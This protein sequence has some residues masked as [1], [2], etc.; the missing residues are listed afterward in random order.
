MDRLTDLMQLA[1]VFELKRLR[2]QSVLAAVQTEEAA[3]RNALAQLD[4]QPRIA[5]GD[6]GQS[7]DPVRLADAEMRWHLWA[8][9]RRRTIQTELAGV[10]ARKADARAALAQAVGK[11]A[12]VSDLLERA[13]SARAPRAD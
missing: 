1:E 2:V 9:A 10:L 12:A 11:H 3:L 5:T 13:R 6:I 8:D 4:R 7:P